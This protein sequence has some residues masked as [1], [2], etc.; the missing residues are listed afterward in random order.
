M[1][2]VTLFGALAV[3]F[4]MVMYVL[5]QRRPVFVLAFAAGCLLASAYRFVSGAW[6]QK[7]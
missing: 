4:M 7:A 5:E 3:S 2:A 6:P 1:N